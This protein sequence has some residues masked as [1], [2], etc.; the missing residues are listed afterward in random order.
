M[1]VAWSTFGL[2]V[3]FAA[4]G[5]L[6]ANWQYEKADGLAQDWYSESDSRGEVI[7][8]LQRLRAVY[9]RRHSQLRED[10]NLIEGFARL[11][12]HAIEDT[13]SRTQ[14]A[15]IDDLVLEIDVKL[16]ALQE[17]ERFGAIAVSI[18]GIAVA[19]SGVLL[20]FNLLCHIGCWI[21]HGSTPNQ[22]SP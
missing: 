10:A 22:D 9:L 6:I 17:L 4:G 21:R 8:S 3:V 5:F 11:D 16:A 2:S 1:I 7:G 12:G 18:A 15:H 20:T 19:A 14:M 13:E